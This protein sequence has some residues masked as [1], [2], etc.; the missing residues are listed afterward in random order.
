MT[1]LKHR[2]ARA[3]S[4]LAAL[5]LPALAAAPIDA[6]TTTG[7]RTASIRQSTSATRG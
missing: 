4:V 7:L 1:P 5:A 6:S 3:L 2:F